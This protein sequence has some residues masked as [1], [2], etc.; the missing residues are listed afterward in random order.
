MS[1]FL[2]N[3]VVSFDAVNDCCDFKFLDYGS[4]STIQAKELRKIRTDFLKLPFQV[5]H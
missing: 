1:Q 2:L 4:Y 5:S 3:Q